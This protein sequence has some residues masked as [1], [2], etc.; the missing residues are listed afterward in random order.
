MGG[1]EMKTSSAYGSCH[2]S[3]PQRHPSYEKWSTTKLRHKKGSWEEKKGKEETERNPPRQVPF[4]R[5]EVKYV[6]HLEFL[7]THKGSSLD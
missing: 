1:W 7:N 6:T 5:S 4:S 2:W 3:L